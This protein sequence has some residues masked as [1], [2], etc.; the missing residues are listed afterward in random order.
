LQL[1]YILLI[2]YYLHLIPEELEIEAD[3]DNK[4]RK[5]Q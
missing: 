3:E 1:S 4:Y 2:T 5:I